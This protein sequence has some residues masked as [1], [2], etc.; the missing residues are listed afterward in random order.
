MK[1]AYIV[2]GFCLLIILSL[3]G[4]KYYDIQ[5]EKAE[6]QKIVKNNG[7]ELVIEHGNSKTFLTDYTQVRLTKENVYFVFDLEIKN[8]K[9]CDEKLDKCYVDT[10]HQ[11]QHLIYYLDN[12]YTNECVWLETGDRETF[13]KLS[14]TKCTSFDNIDIQASLDKEL[15]L[16]NRDFEDMIKFI[17]RLEELGV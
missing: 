2:I 15:D 1:K 16:F 14:D 7:Y 9:Y 12:I 6:L 17:Q 11:N 10:F 8:Y 13:N 3:L 5:K 4:Y